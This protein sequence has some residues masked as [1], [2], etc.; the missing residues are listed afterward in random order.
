MAINF[1]SSGE[2]ANF[3]DQDSWLANTLTIACWCKNDDVG[4]ADG[5][6]LFC[7][8]DDPYNTG[9]L[10]FCNGSDD[11]LSIYIADTIPFINGS[12]FFNGEQGNWLSMILTLD[13]QTTATLYK[14]GSSVAS[15]G[16]GFNDV[17]SNNFDFLVGLQ[18]SFNDRYWKGDIAEFA[19]WNR[20]LNSTEIT[21]LSNKFSPDHFPSGLIMY[22]PFIVHDQDDVIGKVNNT[23]GGATAT[24]VPGMIYPPGVAVGTNF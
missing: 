9:V 22:D 8:L 23:S 1:N 3:G 2:T 19:I 18:N 6:A 11:N 20:V 15:S 7:K 24:H 5:S 12:V 13:S 16:V 4:N 14:N 21:A 17:S 10:A